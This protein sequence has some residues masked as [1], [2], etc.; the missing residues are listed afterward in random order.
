MKA[1][2]DEENSDALKIK[3]RKDYTTVSAERPSTLSGELN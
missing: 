1:K 2:D 3:S